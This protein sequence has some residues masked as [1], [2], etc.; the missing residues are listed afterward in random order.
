[1]SAPYPGH[2]QVPDTM[3][4]ALVHVQLKMCDFQSVFRYIS[5]DPNYFLW[6]YETWDITTDLR[7]NHELNN[8]KMKTLPMP[9]RKRCFLQQ[10]R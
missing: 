2:V 4:V 5:E 7:L 3:V 9:K 6:W 1:M 8:R 10:E